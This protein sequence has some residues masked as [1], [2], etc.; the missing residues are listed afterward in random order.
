MRSL[1]VE[2]GEKIIEA[3]LLLQTVHT[4][5]PGS[6]LFQGQMHAFVAAVLLWPAGPDAFDR[7]AEPQPPNGEFGKIEQAVR[8]G[9]WNAII[10]SDGVRQ[11]ALTKQPPEGGNRQIFAD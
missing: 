6:L 4:R 5:W 8:A 2:L 9:E 7:D 10:G 1:A 11:A 3:R